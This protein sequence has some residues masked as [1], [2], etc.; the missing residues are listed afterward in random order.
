MRRSPRAIVAWILAALVAIATARVVFGDLDALHKRARTL[1]R[2][3]PVVLATRDI[4]LG[5]TLARG[6]LRVVLRPA[7]TVAPDALRDSD[8]VLGRT[9][10]VPLLRDDDVR[11]SALAPAERTGVD[12]LIPTGRRAVHVV[13]ADGFRPPIGAVVD[14]LT[15]L[16]PVAAPGAATAGLAARGAVVLAVDGDDA[17]SGAQGGSGVTLLVTEGEARTVAYA[18]AN[19]RLSLALAPPESAC[20]TSSGTSS[21][22]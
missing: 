18:A 15:A 1:G 16:D 19:G 9:V 2:D 5:T 6:D 11:E 17:Q 7:S 22:P 13:V 4:A 21:T 10:V 3:V 8:G 12:G 20:C 14:V